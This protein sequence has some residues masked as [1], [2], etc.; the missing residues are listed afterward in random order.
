MC[1]RG[2]RGRIHL[3]SHLDIVHPTS[4]NFAN[5]IHIKASTNLDKY[6]SCKCLTLSLVKGSVT[7]QQNH[8][9]FEHIYTRNFGLTV[10][11]ETWLKDEDTDLII[12][13][14][15]DLNKE[16]LSLLSSTRKKTAGVVD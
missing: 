10:I 12:L 4:H 13:Q 15:S 7:L 6:Q 16:K 1:R 14:S 8:T 2:S 3:N 9:L 11:M 5:F